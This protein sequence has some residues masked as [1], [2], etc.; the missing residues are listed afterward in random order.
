LAASLFLNASNPWAFHETD[1]AS[2]LN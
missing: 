2:L 1:L